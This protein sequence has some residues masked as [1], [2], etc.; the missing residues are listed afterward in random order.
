LIVV[1]SNRPLLQQIAADPDM[2]EQ[3]APPP[4]AGVQSK[5]GRMRYYW[6][7]KPKDGNKA[8]HE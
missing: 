4:L 3:L 2:R 1:N 7:K 5:W 6:Y 8:E